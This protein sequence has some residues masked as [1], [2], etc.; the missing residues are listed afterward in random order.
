MTMESRESRGDDPRSS[1]LR[2]PTSDP[3]PSDP[4]VGVVVAMEAELRHLLEAVGVEREE[5]HGPWLE[6]WLT[7]DGV[8]TLALLSGMGMVNAAA[9]TEHLI[10][11]HGPRAV[12]NYGCSG[13]HRRD[14]L[15]GDVVI[16][17][18]AVHHGAVHILASGEELF[19]GSTYEVGGE[20]MPARDLAADP[21]LLARAREAAAG[22]APEPWPRQLFWPPAVP[23]RE[24]RVHAGVVASA[25]IWTQQHARLD[26]LHQRHRSLCE[27]MEAAAIAQVCARHRVPFLPIKD[28]SNN[29]FHVATDLAGDFAEFPTEE[30]GKRA[31]ELTRRVIG[32]TGSVAE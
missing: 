28:I 16:G 2:P 14:I 29:E 21:A 18:A 10:G 4:V 26:A 11:A 31:A 15:P 30:V 17:E 1:D 20:E 13:A 8:P 32:A 12:L 3:R 7:I 22:W 25:D 19:K 24:P 9:A 27:D 5:R 6:R 23:Y